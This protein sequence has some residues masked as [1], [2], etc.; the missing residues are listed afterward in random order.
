MR[1]IIMVGL[2]GFLGANLRYLLTDWVA[3]RW[4]NDFPVA[5]LLV[6]IS[7]SFLIGLLSA[8]AIGKLNIDP[9]LRLFFI[10]G[11]LGAYTTFST[12]MLESANLLLHHWHWQAAI[13]LIGSIL[14][15]LFAA[16]AG[17]SIGAK[18]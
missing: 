2:G 12:Y 6:N 14:L 9:R 7:G 10:T 18:I 8:L 1:E 15:G 4:A 11:V 5:T 13:N 17:L 16:L 3:K